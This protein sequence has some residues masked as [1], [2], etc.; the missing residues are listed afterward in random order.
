MSGSIPSGLPP[1][2]SWGAL[3]GPWA[4]VVPLEDV[5]NGVL[6]VG[7][8]R[9]EPLGDVLA[10]RDLA[11]PLS[12]PLGGAV[13]DALCVALGG[14]PAWLVDGF[15]RCAGDWLLELAVWRPGR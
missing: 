3:D 12:L 13:L 14:P 4:V 9:V 2:V 8:C 15:I 1:S 5:G 10:I 6:R 11:E 7:A